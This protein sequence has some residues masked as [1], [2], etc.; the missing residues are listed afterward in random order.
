M[1]M[2]PLSD[3]GIHVCQG[4]S[5]SQKNISTPISYNKPSP[6]ASIGRGGFVSATWGMPDPKAQ[7]DFFG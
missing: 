1:M 4:T 3:D 2:S 6:I 7:D 5:I